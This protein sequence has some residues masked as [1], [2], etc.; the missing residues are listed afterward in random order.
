MPLTRFSV[1]PISIALQH[2]NVVA[3]RLCF[4]DISLDV[5]GYWCKERSHEALGRGGSI[6]Y[7]S[8]M[9]ASGCGSPRSIL[10]CCWS[11]NE[12]DEKVEKK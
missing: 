5:K 8:F 3:N 1:S 12:E 10:H 9:K 11:E 6:V 7:H 2:S 4:D